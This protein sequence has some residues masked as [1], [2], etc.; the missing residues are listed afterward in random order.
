MLSPL[1]LVHTSV[2]P[3]AVTVELFERF[4]GLKDDQGHYLPRQALPGFPVVYIQVL[5]PASAKLGDGTIEEVMS[6]YMPLEADRVKDALVKKFG[7][8]HPPEDKMKPK[9]IRRI[10]WGQDHLSRGG[11][12]VP[13]NFSQYV[14]PILA[15]RVLV[16]QG[17]VCVGRLQDVDGIE[18]DIRWLNTW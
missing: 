16:W 15:L 12:R 2:Y 4:V 9:G 10:L 17:R 8:S 11:R 1:G 18:G 7:T 3:R 14:V 5:V 6:L 13:C